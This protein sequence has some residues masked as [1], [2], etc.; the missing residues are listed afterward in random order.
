[1]RIKEPSSKRKMYLIVS[2]K[3]PRKFSLLIMEG[4]QSNIVT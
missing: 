2:P 4:I 1:M 3:A